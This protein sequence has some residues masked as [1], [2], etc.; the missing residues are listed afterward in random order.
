MAKDTW[1]LLGVF[2]A[3]FLLLAGMILG[4]YDRLDAR[5]E[6]INLNL[7]SEIRRLGAKLSGE[8][9]RVDAK[10]SSEI[11]LVDANLGGELEKLQEGQRLIRER[12]VRLETA[13]SVA[14]LDLPALVSEEAGSSG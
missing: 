10:L 1:A 4:V 14:G 13:V 9:R 3:G 12:L 11:S 2:A 6:S 7:S 8:I 5:I